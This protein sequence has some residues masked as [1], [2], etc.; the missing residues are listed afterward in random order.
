MK[1]HDICLEAC[2]L[3]RGERGAAYGDILKNH[4]NIADLWSAY[5][6]SE[7]TAHEVAILLVLLKVARTKTGWKP[8]NYVDIAGYGG[9]AGE[10]AEQTK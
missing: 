6:G 4:Q 9:V 2:D 10:I 1:A 8:D 7:I 3:I 5:L